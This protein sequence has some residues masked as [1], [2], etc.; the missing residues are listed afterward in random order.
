M[1]RFYEKHIK[2]KIQAFDIFEL[3]NSFVLFYIALFFTIPTLV[4]FGL[5]S[6]IP[7]NFFYA[8][9]KPMSFVAVLYL[10][11]GISFFIAGYWVNIFKKWRVP[12]N[13][14]F[15][16]PWTPRRTAF[17]FGLVFA[18]GLALKAVNIALGIYSHFG[19]NLSVVNGSLYSIIG[20]LNLIGPLSLALAFAYYFYLLREGN[21]LYKAWRVV[22]WLSFALESLYGFFSWSHFS[23]IVPLMIYL[24]VRHYAYKKSFLQ[25]ILA[26]LLISFAIIPSQSFFRNKDLF[27]I[28]HKGQSSVNAP[29]GELETR[30]GR[31]VFNTSIRRVDQS[32]I[33]EA[34][35]TKTEHFLYGKTLLNFFV[36]LGPPRF[37][38]KDKPVTNADGNELG[39]RYGVLTPDDL[40]TSVGPTVVGDLY[41]NFGLWGITLGMFLFGSFLKFIYDYFIVHTSRS[42]SGIMAYSIVWIEV[43]KGMEDWIAPV[44]AGLVKLMVIIVAVCLLLKS[45]QISI[46]TK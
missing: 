39:R 29:N 14:I 25:I 30:V 38:W 1:K 27:F 12:G 3:G 33:V 8:D 22:A 44:Y 5:P 24:I 18:A 46:T 17:V 13:D 34:L 32:R 2:E 37:I 16:G 31:F 41:M 4:Y 36:S 9:D 6:L 28:G 26:A 11:L 15:R 7:G 43:I 21:R 42:L 20:L 23:V 19:K 35:F 10:F 45:E 40:G